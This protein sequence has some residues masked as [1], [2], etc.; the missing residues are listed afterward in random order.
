MRWSKQWQQEGGGRELLRLAIPL[1]LSSSFMTLQITI[2][3]A[4]LSQSSSGA[5][6][7]AMPAAVLYWTFLTLLQNTASY[8]TTFVAQYTGAGR[9][10]RVGPAVWQALYFSVA[11]GVAFLGLLP[12]AGPLFSLGGSGEGSEEEQG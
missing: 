4:L 2:D 8:A 3:R 7:A 1:I 9:P 5:V 11:G 6:A 10:H 12:L